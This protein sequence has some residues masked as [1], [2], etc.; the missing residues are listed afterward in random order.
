MNQQ[1]HVLSVLIPAFNE[2]E[3]IVRVLRRVLALG[4][5]VREVIVVDDGSQDRTPELVEE[6]AAGHPLVRFCRLPRNSGK[7]AAIQRALDMATGEV[8][9][10][11]D[12]DLECDPAEI[13]DVVGPIV[14]GDADVVYGSRT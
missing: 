13:P 5:L 3:T 7:T 2:E 1:S 4:S 12:A 11:Q 6:Y 14:A 10:V 9:I 8:I